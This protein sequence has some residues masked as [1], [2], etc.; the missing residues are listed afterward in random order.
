MKTISLILAALCAA[1][2]ARASD[3]GISLSVE[4][5]TEYY[6]KFDDSFA[7]A[8][9]DP[10]KVPFEAV[11]KTAYADAVSSR[12]ANCPTVNFVGVSAQ[13]TGGTDNQSSYSW[14]SFVPWVAGKSGGF[15]GPSVNGGKSPLLPIYLPC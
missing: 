3:C 6:W 7:L 10:F 15:D 13:S 2:T 14:N 4:Q 8:D 1:A 11:W 12:W 5:R 9:Q